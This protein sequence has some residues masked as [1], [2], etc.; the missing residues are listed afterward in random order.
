MGMK[1][2]TPWTSW[3]VE[4][5]DD[6][7]ASFKAANQLYAMEK[8]P[9]Q[10]VFVVNLLTLGKALIID[11]KVQSTL[12]DEFVYH[13]S[14]VHPPLLAHGNPERV[15]IL[16][17]GEGAT[18]REVLRYKT[19]KKAV[20]VDIDEKVVEF[21]KKYLQEWHHNSFFDKRAEVIIEDGRKYLENAGKSDEKFD[22]I[23][24][25]LVDPLAGSPA[26]KLYTRE[27]YQL[28]KGALKEGGVM[29]T[30][31]TSPVLY[32]EMFAT[33]HSTIK[34]VFKI[35][36]PYAVYMRSYN[37]LWGFVFGSEEK[38][39]LQLNESEVER[40]IREL[41]VNPEDLRY[42]DGDAHIGMFK[43]PK[44]LK[45]ALKKYTDI[46]TDEKPKYLEI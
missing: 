33:I 32:Q 38:D 8:T 9:Y 2:L 5:I 39:P 43:I 22:A 18:L 4:W 41:L 20:M 26:V 29:V 35:A 15:L 12:F 7:D 21:S 42:Y 34:S 30:Q 46:S 44:N 11:G 23:V 19:V 45:Q 25:D 40:R 6:G 13:E 10:E 27:F 16:G 36:R 24:I 17:G 37:G 31:A 14:L 28:V 3:Y 1:K